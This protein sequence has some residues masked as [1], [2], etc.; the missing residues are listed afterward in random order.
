MKELLG[1]I[2]CGGRST[3]MGSDKGLLMIQNRPWAKVIAAKLQS[4]NLPVVVSVNHGQFDKYQEALPEFTLIQDKLPV[5]GPL[6]GL[7]SVH[8][9]YPQK[10]LL[11][12]ACD[13]IDMEQQ[14][15]SFL[16]QTYNE[17]TNFDFYV[18][19]LAD[20]PQPF[21]AIYTAQALAETYKALQENKI[22]KY[23][24]RNRF[25]AGNTKYIPTANSSAFSNHNS[26]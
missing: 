1:V 25:E 26:L 24:L 14:T 16:I 21:C 3:R 5:Q 10:D 2:L 9:A 23:S 6:N 17:Q 15:L 12:M 20:F 8:D 13:L 22:I 19:E 11:L 18:Y 4:I 7:L